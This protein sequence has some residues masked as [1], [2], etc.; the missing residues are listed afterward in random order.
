MDNFIA[1]IFFA[2]II[3]GCFCDRIAAWAVNWKT[4]G[5]KPAKPEVEELNPDTDQ[6]NR[7]FRRN[8]ELLRPELAG[9]PHKVEY[10]LHPGPRGRC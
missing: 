3:A 8:V 5:A 9:K 7:D 1:A 10:W 4:K 6:L 2:L